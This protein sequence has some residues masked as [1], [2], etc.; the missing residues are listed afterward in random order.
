LPVHQQFV[1]ANQ[2]VGIAARHKPVDRPPPQPSLV[3][4]RLSL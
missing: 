2:H 4:R 1:A 3:R